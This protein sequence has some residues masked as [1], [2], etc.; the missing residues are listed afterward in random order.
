MDSAAAET[1]LRGSKRK[2]EEAL[3][4]A[5]KRIKALDQDVVNKIAA[6]EIIVAPV[7][8]LKELIENA[9][10]AGSTSLEIVV[11]DGGLKL[12]QITD[13]GHGINRD[14]MAILCER[15]TTSKLKTFEDLTTIGTYGFRGEALASISHI[16]HLTIT[17]KTA[18]SSCA[19]RA[20]YADGKLTPAKPGQNADPKPIAGRG[21]TQ[22]TVEDLFYNV[23]SRKRAFRSPSEEYAKILDVVGRYAVHC[24]GVAFSCKKHA[25]S[26]TSISIPVNATTVDSIRHIYGSAVANELL[27]FAV[28]DQKWGFKASGWASNANYHVKKTTILLFINHRSVESSAVKKAIEQLYSAFLPKGGHPFVYLSLDIDPQRVDVNIHPTKREVNFLNEDEI[29]ESIC[30]AVHEQLTQV[31]TSRT[32]TTQSLLPSST[33]P[34]G[35]TNASSTAKSTQARAKTQTPAR[36]YENNLVRTDPNVRKITSM[37]PSSTAGPTTS[38]P[39]APNAGGPQYRHAPRE[40]TDCNLITIKHL[41]ATVRSAMHAGL[42]EIFASH[43][44]VGLVDP[45]RRIVAI[46]SGVKLFLVDYGL[47]SQEYFYQLGLANFGNFGAI[48]FEA[49][50][51]I[52]AL[53]RLGVDKARE[54]EAE[55]ETMPPEEWDAVPEQVTRQL[56]ERR[57]MLREYFNLD[58]SERGELITLPLLLKGYTPSLAKLPRFLMRLGPCVEWDDE[59]A[60]FESF[61]RELARFYTLEQLPPYPSAAPAQAQ[62]DNAN[63][64]DMEGA[65]QTEGGEEM[66]GKR[67]DMERVLEHVLFPALKARLVASQDLLRGVIEVADLKGLYRVFE[68]C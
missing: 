31:D 2:A 44:Y 29:I 53:V 62:K 3:P 38:N 68:R 50:L 13:N 24:T 48:T 5:P 54:L 59:A 1:P 37:L 64:V 56:I 60:C 45:L 57:D 67:Q 19:W 21:G 4:Q 10:D 39:S 58:V 30:T 7:H 14:D 46:Q 20:H 26:A 52:R 22:I 18:D 41:R 28:S 51:D 49:P 33:R 34:P 66:V 9:V 40:R 35:A 32:F 63:E 43:T 6:G 36:P 17:T 23:P 8:A 12:L 42:T 11:K 47:I 15:F 27:Q 55:A 25:D 16:A 61:L 65:A